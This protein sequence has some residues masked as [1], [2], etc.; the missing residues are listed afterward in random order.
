M[1]AQTR[2]T[3]VEEINNDRSVDYGII[4][5]HNIVGNY[6]NHCKYSAIHHST[7]DYDD[8]DDNDDYDD[9]DDY[10]NKENASNESDG[11]RNGSRKLKAQVDQGKI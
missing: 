7:A 11:H 9:Y 10:N 1:P 3:N 4:L 6:D 8:Y 5:L 2:A